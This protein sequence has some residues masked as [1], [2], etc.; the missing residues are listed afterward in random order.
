[1]KEEL[2]KA[3]KKAFTKLKL[4][5]G[6]LFECPIEK[7]FEYDARKL[8]EVCINHK[9]A[10]YLEKYVLPLF[11]NTKKK[12]F[13]DIEF[14]KEGL[15]K[16]YLQLNEKEELVRPDIIIH[17]R[18]TRNKKI[19]FL[20]VECKKR[21]SG[22]NIIAK[23]KNKLIS[24]LYDSRYKYQFALQVLYESGTIEGILF[25]LTNGHLNDGVNIKC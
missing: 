14:N 22:L 19:N 10:N 15:N 24:F 16:K 17:N 1:M 3:I 6:I 12:L 4:I 9:L 18:K 20:V 11:K 5:D 8:H 21:D 23:D 7:Y 13:V 25:Y 2:I